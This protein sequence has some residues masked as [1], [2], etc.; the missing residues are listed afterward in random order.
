MSRAVGGKV[1]VLDARSFVSFHYRAFL[2]FELRAKNW[3]ERN[4]SAIG[5]D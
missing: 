1:N 4:G 3:R 2:S 5:A